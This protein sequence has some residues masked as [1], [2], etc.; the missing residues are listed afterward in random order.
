[1]KYFLSFIGIIFLL[2]TC[3]I[4]VLVWKLR[5]HVR[6][7]RDALQNNMD[8]ETFRRM[9]DKDYWRKKEKEG[10][11]FDD[12]YFKGN[13]NGWRQDKKKADSHSSR[14]TRTKEG[15]TIIDNRDPSKKIFT[16]DEGEYVD[17]REE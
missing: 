5:K 9:S 14:T 10:P 4:A 6:R 1:M 12:E 11:A 15:V 13:P 16:Q 7:M 2:F 8:D 17:Y 3:G